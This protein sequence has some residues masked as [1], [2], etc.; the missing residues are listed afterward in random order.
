MGKCCFQL[1]VKDQYF[2]MATVDAFVQSPSEELLNSCTK[3]E[4]LK[5]VEHYDVDVGDKELKDEVKGVL[6]AAL[7]KKGVLP[8]KMKTLVADVDQ[9]VVSTTVALSFEQQK[10]LLLLQMER[11]K[12]SIEKERVRHTPYLICRQFLSEVEVTVEASEGGR[13]SLSGSPLLRLCKN[14]SQCSVSSLK[15]KSLNLYKFLG[16]GC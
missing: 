7:V 8:G 3:E 9:S 14:I 11:D 10:E 15:R 1:H 4:L 6:Q 12:L 16:D 13:R 2:V 5:L